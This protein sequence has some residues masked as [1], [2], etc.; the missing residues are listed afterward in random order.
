MNL[1]ESSIGSSDI[2][3]CFSQ[4]KGTLDDDV[5][6]GK[7]TLFFYSCTGLEIHL[8]SYSLTFLSDSLSLL[9][10]NCSCK[11]LNMLKL[12]VPSNSFYVHARKKSLLTNWLQKVHIFFIRSRLLT[13]L[14]TNHPKNLIFSKKYV[15]VK[16]FNSLASQFMIS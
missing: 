10:N 16:I 6:E 12:S 11:T 1:N 14:F 9:L 13:V 4:V 7:I 5:T 15:Y 2:Q 8:L 3:W